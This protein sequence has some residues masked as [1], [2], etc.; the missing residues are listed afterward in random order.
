MKGV[1]ASPDIRRHYPVS[2][3]A[4][5][6]LMQ[7]VN[8]A[9]CSN[10]HPHARTHTHIHTHRVPSFTV[11]LSCNSM[12]HKMLL[13]SKQPHQQN[14]LGPHVRAIGGTGD[15]QGNRRPAAQ[16]HK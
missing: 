13:P 11:F 4:D 7:V 9:Q 14:K 10:K 3:N 2:G 15:F 6:I 5:C 8:V 12:A 16:V 1:N